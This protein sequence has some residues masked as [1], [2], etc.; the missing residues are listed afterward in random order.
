MR[1]DQRSNDRQPEP[2]PALGPRQR[3]VYLPERLE[4]LVQGRARDGRSQVR[5]GEDHP[6]VFR[7]QVHGHGRFARPMRER[8]SHQVRD[9]LA[10]VGEVPASGQLATRVERD[11]SVRVRRAAAAWKARLAVLQNIDE[12]RVLPGDA[13]AL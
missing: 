2:E 13:S 1:L 6:A 11:A 9:H 5:N 12:A 4:E 3:R 7:R 10:E 8:I